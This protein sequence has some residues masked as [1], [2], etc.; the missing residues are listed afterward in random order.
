MMNEQLWFLVE[1][2][3]NLLLI[4]SGLALTMTLTKRWY[5]KRNGEDRPQDYANDTH[6]KITMWFVL[7]IVFLLVPL[8]NL[9]RTSGH[10]VF[11]F[12]TLPLFLLYLLIG[13]YLWKKV[14]SNKD[15]YWYDWW[16]SGGF[17]VW[18]VLFM[19]GKQWWGI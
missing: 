5:R 7:I 1:L 9:E 16:L 3:A 10:L 8:M 13:T 2:F 15:D 19:M 6:Q 14:S 4:S 18:F 12:I 11:L 17:L